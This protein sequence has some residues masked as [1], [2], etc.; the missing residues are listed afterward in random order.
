[1]AHDSLNGA[2]E[3]FLVCSELEKFLQPRASNSRQR[4]AMPRRGAC[5]RTAMADTYNRRIRSG[6]TE[7]TATKS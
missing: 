6:E 7:I 5:M 3:N 1:V 2:L 4:P